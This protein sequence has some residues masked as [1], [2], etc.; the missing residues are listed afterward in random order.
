MRARFFVSVLSGLWLEWFQWGS[1]GL[2]GPM[3]ADAAKR[4]IPNLQTPKKA[5]KLK[6]GI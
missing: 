2:H 1:F 5:P 4:Q 6:R 3:T